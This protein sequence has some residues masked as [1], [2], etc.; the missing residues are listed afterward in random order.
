MTNDA[1]AGRVL[2][3]A[4]VAGERVRL[5]VL[6]RV[7]DESAGEVLVAVDALVRSGALVVAPDAGEAWFADETAR[8]DAE[9]RLPLADRAEL[10]RRTAEVLEADHGADSAEIV[11][12]WLGAVA[13]TAGRL[14]RSRRQLRLAMAC[15]RAG[16][17]ATAHATTQSIVMTARTE[18]SAELLAEAAVVLEPIGQSVW[19]G[20]IYQWCT[21]ALAASG[22]PPRT[23]VR[24]LARQAQ[25]ASYLGRWREAL[26]A[27]SEALEQAESIGDSD[28]LA[29]ALTARQLATSGPDDVEELTAAAERM[30]QLGT[31][32][33]VA[34]TELRGRLWRVDALWYGGDLSAIA[35]EIGRIASCAGRAGGPNGRWHVLI[36]RASLALARAEFDD[37]EALLDDAL[38]EFRRIG[39]PAAHG[40]EVAFR[41]LL[42]HH[43]G[44]A[45]ALLGTAAWQFGTDVRWDLSARLARAF[46]LVDANRLDEAAALYQRCGRPETW[47]GWRAAELLVSAI[48]ARVAAAVGATD[49]VRRFRARLEPQRGR[50]VVGGAGATNFLGPVEL[51]LGI[52]AASLGEWD[53]AAE[54]LRTACARSR[55]IG[56]PGFA[57]ES[58]CLLAETYERSGDRSQARAVA[59]ET[60]T[61][62]RT[63]GMTPWTH[64]LEQ[65]ATPDDP[66]SP[67]E[68]EVARLVADG[69]SNRAIAAALVISERTAQNHVQHVL[70]KLG[71]ASRAQVAAWVA[72]RRR[73]E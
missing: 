29:E 65:L 46:V 5:D 9:D 32:T 11:R 57:V 69:L 25:A 58:A 51:A 3:A 10:H 41:M 22:L 13:A 66:L 49:D 35:A 33:G 71:F 21:E 42:G 6:A 19:D 55:T 30:I 8:R 48:A 40:A 16:D 39:H 7:V 23:S 26:A 12:H 72:G 68:Q 44:H 73:A 15:V 47:H 18:Q 31:T 2:S 14:E 61:L 4:A 59:G 38:A 50:Y 43:R 34:A 60:L 53:A 24:L 1:V 36:T 64:R 62:A 70:T 56:A 28:L 27:S 37:A 52:C 67:R 45:D 20:D 17:L 63:L 54:D